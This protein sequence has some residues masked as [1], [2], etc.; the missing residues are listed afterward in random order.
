[1]KVLKSV[2]L[3]WR[4]RRLHTTC[5]SYL[6][7]L[8]HQTH[9]DIMSIGEVTPG[10]TGQEYKSRRDKLAQAIRSNGTVTDTLSV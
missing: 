2:A 9:P 10:I 4:G 3:L 5:Q 8:S 7:Q 1:M 6:G